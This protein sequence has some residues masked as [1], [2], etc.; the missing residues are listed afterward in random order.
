MAI[1]FRDRHL[2]R[3]FDLRQWVEAE[4][5]QKRDEKREQRQAR[6][7]L[8][9]DGISDELKEQEAS[10]ASGAA[11]FLIDQYVRH[12]YKRFQDSKTPLNQI[13]IRLGEGPPSDMAE[14]SPVIAHAEPFN[15]CRAY[16]FRDDTEADVVIR[17]ITR[18][19]IRESD[20][21]KS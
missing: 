4:L 7:K 9:C 5:P 10:N 20:N 1:A 3:C 11:R 21:A 16:I 14:L 17:N 19:K 15:L 6:V 13:L 12:P 18:T 8:V 2:T